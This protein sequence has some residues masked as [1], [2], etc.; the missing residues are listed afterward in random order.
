MLYSY[1]DVVFGAESV[2]SFTAMPDREYGLN[3]VIF[4]P[5]CRDQYI[6]PYSD[7]YQAFVLQAISRIKILHRDH[8][9]ISDR[10]SRLVLE[11]GFD[12]WE[13]LSSVPL[14]SP[15]CWPAPT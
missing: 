2:E 9:Q 15:I 7:L 3:D 8:D 6:S 10:F 1:S 5:S 4:L 14:L 13:I 11:T 12:K